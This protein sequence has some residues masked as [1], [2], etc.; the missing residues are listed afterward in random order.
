MSLLIKVGAILENSLR[1][2]TKVISIRNGIYGLSGWTTR[3]S[4]E[5]ANVSTKFV[6][7]YGL[8]YANVKVVGGTKADKATAPAKSGAPTDT[9]KPT[10][11]SLNK[12]NAKAV[13]E[14]AEKLGIESDGTRAVVL[15][16]LF[17]HFEL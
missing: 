2:Y 10:K 17:A 8:K 14:L 11:S 3:E 9:E 7:I 1:Q 4:A 5:K 16:R 15:E 6:N 13:K 12:L